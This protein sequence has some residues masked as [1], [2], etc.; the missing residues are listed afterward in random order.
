[1]TIVISHASIAGSLEASV[2]V[3]E[4]GCPEDLGMWWRGRFL[5]TFMIS[6]TI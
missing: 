3:I 2:T 4:L 5:G 1:M 6:R